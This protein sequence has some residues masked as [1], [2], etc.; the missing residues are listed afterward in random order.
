MGIFI[1][2]L[3][4]L[5]T[6]RRQLRAN[7]RSNT[8][9]RLSHLRSNLRYNPQVTMAHLA[10]SKTSL[11][12]CLRTWDVSHLWTKTMARYFPEVIPSTSQWSTNQLA[13][14]QYHSRKADLNSKLKNY[15]MSLTQ[16]VCLSI[17][18]KIRSL[19]SQALLM[20]L[21]WLPL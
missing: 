14:I 19:R 13:S 17:Y 21:K 2:W 15:M 5:A 10:T 18:L 12:T 4:Q 8:T 1:M 6:P 11:T 20:G 3:D 7:L 16:R 9:T